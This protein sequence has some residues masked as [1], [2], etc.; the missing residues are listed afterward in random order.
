MSSPNRYSLKRVEYLT[1]LLLAAIV[2]AVL[3][4][5]CK[6]SHAQDTTTATPVL[7]R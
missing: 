5:R 7:N 2:T 6:Q 3:L 4:P 1:V